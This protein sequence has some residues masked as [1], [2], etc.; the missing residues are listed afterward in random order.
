MKINFLKIAVW[1]GIVVFDIFVYLVLS[2]FLMNYED[3]W[4]GSKGELWSLQS[5]SASEKVFFFSHIAW[6]GLNIAALVYLLYNAFIRT[7]PY[8]K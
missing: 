3:H 1:T 2:L 5:M 8:G 4:D 6:N 7:K